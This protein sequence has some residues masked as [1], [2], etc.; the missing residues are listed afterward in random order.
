MEYEDTGAKKAQLMALLMTVLVVGGAIVYV[1]LI[2]GAVRSVEGKLTHWVLS[3]QDCSELER[4]RR[5]LEKL[6]ALAA[7][8]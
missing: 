7:T 8:P 3:F 4:L 2:L 6:R 1:E 5:E